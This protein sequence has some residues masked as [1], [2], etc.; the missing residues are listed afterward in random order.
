VHVNE[1]W[2]ESLKCYKIRKTSKH[3]SN[4]VTLRY[5]GKKSQR[6]RICI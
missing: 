4:M 1:M 2:P 5:C 6:K 3:I